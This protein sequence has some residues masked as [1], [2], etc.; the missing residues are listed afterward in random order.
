MINIT[1]IES[2]KY[3]K[4]DNVVIDVAGRKV[5]RE[6]LH[7]PDAVAV[8]IYSPVDEMVLLQEQLRPAI[9]EAD[10]PLSFARILEI[11]AGMIDPGEL[12]IDAAVREVK[13]ETGLTINRRDLR[14]I[15]SFLP[16]PGKMNEVVHVFGY[17]VRELPEIND[18]S[19]EET[20]FGLIENRWVSYSD[21]REGEVVICDAK[22]IIALHSIGL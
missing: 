16:S 19:S 20:E 3:L 6:R 17:A 1:P 21:I 2:P 18:G 14:Y 22:T 11:P 7:S 9:C 12:D 13:E 5:S 4:I 8:L 15:K 10:L